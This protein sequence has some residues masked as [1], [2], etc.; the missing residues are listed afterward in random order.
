MARARFSGAW[1]RKSSTPSFEVPLVQERDPEHLEPTPNVD[2]VVGDPIWRESAPGAPELPV[3]WTHDG[4]AVPIGGGGP[5]DMDPLDPMIG[6]GAGHG[7]TVAESQA[8]RTR[9]MSKRDG[10]VEARIWQPAVDRDGAPHVAVIPDVP[11]DG[12]SPQTLQLERSGVGQPNDPFAR[13]GKRIKRWYDRYIDMHRY[14]VELRPMPVRNAF[15]AQYQPPVMAGNQYDSPFPT[16]AAF[17]ATPDATTLPQVRRT[18]V[19]WTT[20]VVGDAYSANLNEAGLPTW[21]L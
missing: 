21:G 19:E 11:L 20:P 8:I 2:V 1:G 14:Q 18:P 10:S 15:T 7:D 3:A 4:M 6:P 16:P 13:T 9:W 5:I 17:R 12:D